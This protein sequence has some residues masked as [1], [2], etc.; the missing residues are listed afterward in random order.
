MP[1]FQP[2]LICKDY[3][4]QDQDRFRHM[5]EDAI[6]AVEDRDVFLSAIIITASPLRGVYLGMDVHQ[7]TEDLFAQ[8]QS[9]QAFAEKKAPYDP[10]VFI[11]IGNCGDV[12]AVRDKALRAIPGV[13]AGFTVLVD[14]GIA[15]RPSPSLTLR[16]LR[17][18]DHIDPEHFDGLVFFN[19]RSARDVIHAFA[20]GIG[21]HAG[22]TTV[23]EPFKFR[24]NSC[25][26][27]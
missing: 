22:A 10:A 17:N 7:V 3:Q 24:Q 5:L 26:A 9:G 27:A 16:E 14:N 8:L 21:T 12:A 11:D 15:T 1:R 23:V 4:T 20:S 6:E 18:I 2:I 13:H 25:L 19:H